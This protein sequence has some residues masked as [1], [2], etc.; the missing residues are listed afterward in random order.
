MM[1]PH[2]LADKIEMALRES[3]SPPLTVQLL[4]GTRLGWT[5]EIK[6][7]IGDLGKTLRYDVAASGYAGAHQGEFLYDMVWYE[8]DTRGFVLSHPMAMEVEY[9]ISPI[10]TVDDDFQKLVQARADV[11][12]WV[13]TC[14]KLSDI[15]QH[16]ANCI[17][18]IG[19]F[20]GSLGDDQ[21]VLLFFEWFTKTCSVRR[22][23]EL[24]SLPGG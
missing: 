16:V 13:T 23:P 1:T 20:K 2:A 17:E 22:L 5:Q 11:R 19:V 3:L 6:R 14:A 15:D 21:Y 7:V 18:Q 12:V 4:G 10:S 24:S 8:V 9:G